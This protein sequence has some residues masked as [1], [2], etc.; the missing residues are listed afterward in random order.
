MSNPT[1]LRAAKAVRNV[2]GAAVVGAAAL[3]GTQKEANAD[4]IAITVSGGLSQSYWGTSYDGLTYDSTT[5]ATFYTSIDSNTPV[6]NPSSP[7]KVYNDGA[8]AATLTI[9]TGTEN[10]TYNLSN[11]S[12]SIF[13]GT[14][15]E[16]DT[17]QINA[18]TLGS[19][20]SGYSAV[21]MYASFGG[22]QFADDSL[23]ALSNLTAIGTSQYIFAE[24]QSVAN[25]FSFDSV[26]VSG[27]PEPTTA[28][29]LGIG[30]ATPLLKRRNIGIAHSQDL[31][32][33]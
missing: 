24:N 8:G 13:S 31:S 10:R 28:L 32:V 14:P 9:Q 5:K 12:V 33:K 2:A 19:W 17:I 30:L 29:L 18:L 20:V 26:T 6:Q 15:A 16:N 11:I 3:M 4:V 22:N 27:V 21:G 25:H 1:T 23:S 7:T